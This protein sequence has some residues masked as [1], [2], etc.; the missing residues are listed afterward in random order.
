MWLFG[1]G[2]WKQH[3]P[4]LQVLNRDN[5]FR[6]GSRVNLQI[7]EQ[8]GASVGRF[9]HERPRFRLYSSG[10]EQLEPFLETVC[11]LENV[12]AVPEVEPQ[13]LCCLQPR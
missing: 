1:H 12:S 8:I 4:G 5:Y 2:D 10:G 6:P 13:A 3:L 9:A 11:P 7:V